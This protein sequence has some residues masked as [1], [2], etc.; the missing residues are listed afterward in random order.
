MDAHVFKE[1]L[2]IISYFYVG[3]DGRDGRDGPAGPPGSAGTPGLGTNES[4][5]KDAGKEI[6]L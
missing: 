6:M 3:R 1:T 2:I 4:V 5:L